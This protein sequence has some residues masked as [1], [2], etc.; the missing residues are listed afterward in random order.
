MNAAFGNNIVKLEVADLAGRANGR[1][2]LN[3]SAFL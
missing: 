2:N 3:V 1:N